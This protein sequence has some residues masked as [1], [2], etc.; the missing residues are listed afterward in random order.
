VC[1]NPDNTRLPDPALACG[2]LPV[3]GGSFES[4]GLVQTGTPA[5]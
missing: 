2:D 5:A 3:C 4:G 1:L